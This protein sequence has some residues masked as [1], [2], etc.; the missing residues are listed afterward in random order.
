MDAG[1]WK[2]G[3]VAAFATSSQIRSKQSLRKKCND[4]DNM[5]VTRRRSGVLCN[6]LWRHC[7]LP[8]AKWKENDGIFDAS[9]KNSLVAEEAN[10]DKYHYFII[11]VVIVM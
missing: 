9:R 7:G 10:D 8:C 1:K 3:D 4:D 5:A 2:N 6:R 11:I